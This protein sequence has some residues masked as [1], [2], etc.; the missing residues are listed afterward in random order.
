VKCG[1][2]T[3]D[4]CRGLSGNDMKEKIPNGFEG[5]KT[6]ISHLKEES[7]SIEDGSY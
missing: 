5:K 2:S 3:N 6:T 4:L 1:G 7:K